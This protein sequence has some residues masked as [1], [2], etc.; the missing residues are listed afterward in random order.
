MHTVI[1]ENVT[2]LDVVGRGSYGTVYEAVWRGTIV[3]V[4]L[5][6]IGTHFKDDCAF[7]YIRYGLWVYVPSSIF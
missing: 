3:A 2:L 5:L 1:I 6:H 4:K 7:D